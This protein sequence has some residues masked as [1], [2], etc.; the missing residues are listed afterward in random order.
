MRKA[1]NVSHELKFLT[2]EMQRI[3]GEFFFYIQIQ[4]LMQL[5]M[6]VS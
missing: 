2:F 1:N 4:S 6:V 3:E 5:I